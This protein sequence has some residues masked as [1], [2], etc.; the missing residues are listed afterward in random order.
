MRIIGGKHGGRILSPSMKGWPT[1]PTT[2]IAKE[3]LFNMLMNTVSFSDTKMLDL[4]GGT[5]NHSWEFLSRGCQDVTY[6]DK[7]RGC[8]K[9]VQGV[10]SALKYEDHFT[11]INMDVK[12]FIKYNEGQYDYIFA[13]PPYPLKWLDEIPDLVFTHQLLAD[14]GLFVLE[15][16]PNHNFQRHPHYVKERRYG[17]TIFA[18]FE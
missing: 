18:F 12:R 8:V 14:D 2:D 15:H 6:V 3:G 7:Y 17:E 9:F 10:R 13:G 11:V 4:F 1:R 5:G 16:N